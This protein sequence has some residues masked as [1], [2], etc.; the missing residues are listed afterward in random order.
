MHQPAPANA[1]INPFRSGELATRAE[2]LDLRLNA[3]DTENP[4]LLDG[5]R[6]RE[7]FA[8]DA[9]QARGVFGLASRETALVANNVLLAVGAGPAIG[10]AMVK[11]TSRRPASPQNCC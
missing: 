7:I 5:E 2:R 6:A 4:G 8:S 10:T 1:P 9:M 11:P 3:I